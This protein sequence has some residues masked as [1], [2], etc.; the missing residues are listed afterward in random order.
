MEECSNIMSEYLR[1]IAIVVTGS[2]PK[3]R[4]GPIPNQQTQTLSEPLSEHWISHF[5][6]QIKAATLN[7]RFSR[8]Q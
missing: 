5:G 7:V 6:V 3:S 4:S 2:F 1:K 8:K